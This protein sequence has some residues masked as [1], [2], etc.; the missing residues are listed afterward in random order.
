MQDHHQGSESRSFDPLWYSQRYHGGRLKP[1]EAQ[2]DFQT[3]GRQ[4][5]LA[6]CF[7][8]EADAYAQRTNALLSRS[9][10]D[11]PG[12]ARRLEA[13]RKKRQKESELDSSF[14]IYSAV[15]KN[16]DSLK[17]P[18]FLQPG[19]SYVC[20]SDAPEW[21]TGIWEIRPLPFHN[22]DT[23]RETRYVK[24]HPHYLFPTA[25]LAVWV[26]M[27][28]LLLGDLSREI[29][30]FL[31]SGL[32]VATFYHPT[33]QTIAEEAEV[34]KR[35][36][37]DTL[38][39][40]EAQL[41]SYLREDR[42]PYFV[43]NTNVV[44]YNLTHPRLGGFLAAWWKELE[45][46]TKRDQLSF[47][48]ALAESG[49]SWFPLAQKGICPSNHPAFGIVPHDKNLGI[50]RSITRSLARGM[51]DPMAQTSFFEEREEALRSV[52]ESSVDIVICVHNAPEATK[53]CLES[54]LA[55]RQPKQRI[56]LIDDA[57]DA[58]TAEYLQRLAVRCPDLSLTRHT[59]CL[60]YTCSANEGLA[61]A[62]GDYVI[63]L[64]SDTIVTEDW[65]GKIVYA[66]AHSPGAGLAGPLSNA[67]DAQSLPDIQGSAENSAIN[68]LP[69]GYS[70][71]D[72]SR[73][74]EMWSPK[75]IYARVPLLHGFCLGLTRDAL[76]RLGGF[77]ASLFP[78]GYGEENDLSFR[79]A[80]C[81]ID[82]IL[83]T[84]TYVYH[85]K[86]QSFASAERMQYM[87]EGIAAL[88]TKYG[89]ERVRRSIRTM[90]HHPWLTELRKRMQAVYQFAE[91][92]NR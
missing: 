62:R 57:S 60:G 82:Q 49:Q 21:N 79:A 7:E 14:V 50:C 15:A 51:N 56:V 73:F 52:R 1:E 45:R 9:L 44:F 66:L 67:A 47:S 3:R 59:Q 46:H 76:E 34:C 25:R 69:A 87:R 20:F 81:G 8:E 12:F 89:E 4:E 84:T 71:N 75:D 30:A 40:L 53:R 92:R 37:K 48:H 22:R 32:P 61:L 6:S 13:W 68:P 70:P 16:Y 18:H 42:G 17:V 78:R 86:S 58:P 80:E 27:N 10:T 38:A 33:R 39:G 26:D 41:Q 54:V 90:L 43:A 28:V 19:A 31:D 36:H 85:E 64:N 55:F 11:L 24:L 63:L 91:Q 83:V 74:L 88:M 29:E 2:N 23:T 72:L 65:V 5:G 77:D 35:L